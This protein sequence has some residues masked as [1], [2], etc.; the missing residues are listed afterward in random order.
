MI[1]HKAPCIK[2]ESGFLKK[3]LKDVKKNMTTFIIKEYWL[4]FDTTRLDVVNGTGN[5]NSCF[6]WYA[7]YIY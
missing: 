2:K 1:L 4:A 6:A 5:C 7:N 3:A